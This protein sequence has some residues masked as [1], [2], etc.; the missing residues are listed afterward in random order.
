MTA[1]EVREIIIREIGDDPVRQNAHGCSF[2]RCLV[3]PHL[4][5]FENC[6]PGANGTIKLWVVLE[7]NP[8]TRDGY[9]IVFEEAAGAFGLA[10]SGEKIPVYIG[11]YGS[12]MQT[13]DAM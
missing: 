12:F 9:K 1:A 10:V 7:E 6:A 13:Y 3:E 11:R 2:D 4:I 8:E 5:E